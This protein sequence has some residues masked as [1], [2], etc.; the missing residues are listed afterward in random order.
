MPFV[1][2][3]GVRIHWRSDGVEGL[4]LGEEVAIAV[5]E[6]LRLTGAELFAGYSL[7]RFD[8]RRVVVG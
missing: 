2:R 8:G 4:K 6:E 5:L 3:A 7:R 1:D